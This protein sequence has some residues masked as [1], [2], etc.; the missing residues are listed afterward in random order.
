[1]YVAE[2]VPLTAIVPRL[3]FPPATPF[4]S[5]A[6]AVPDGAQ[7]V[8]VKFCDWPS[9][10]L[11]AGGEIVFVPPQV[12]VIVTLAD[13]DFETSATLVAVTVTEGGSGAA[14]GAV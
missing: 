8:V 9:A 11:A 7:I 13:A 4:T 2:F 10:T 3:A 1:M 6:I 5:H 12:A 14:A